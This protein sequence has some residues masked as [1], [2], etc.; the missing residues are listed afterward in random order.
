MSCDTARPTMV[1]NVV[2]VMPLAASTVR[3]SRAALAPIAAAVSMPLV[4]AVEAAT[5]SGPRATICLPEVS[6]M[7]LPMSWIVLDELHVAEL[8][9]I[10]EAAP[11][12]PL[13]AVPEVEP[14]LDAAPFPRAPPNAVPVSAAALE[15]SSESEERS[16]H[17]DR[18]IAAVLAAP[19]AQINLVARICLRVIGASLN[20]RGCLSR[21][22]QR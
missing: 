3:S 21:D 14:M 6:R 10:P 15:L 17:D 1:S 12:P 13:A 20:L 19:I 7:R 5:I 4:S 8:P 2:G 16:V 22:A 11:V 18:N 9:T